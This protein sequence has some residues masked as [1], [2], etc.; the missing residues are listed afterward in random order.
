LSSI[1]DA[2]ALVGCIF[3][4]REEDGVARGGKKPATSLGKKR[5][6][7]YVLYTYEQFCD[8]VERVSSAPEWERGLSMPLLCE[9]KQ[10]QSDVSYFR[11][12]RTSV[13]VEPCSKK[14]L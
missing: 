5:K 11:F 6:Y 8:I 3:Q 2:A 13:F 4:K 9:G 7:R 1:I 10:E 14:M 12:C